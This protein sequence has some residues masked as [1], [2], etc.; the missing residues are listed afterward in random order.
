M[1][2]QQRTVDVTEHRRPEQGEIP[3]PKVGGQRLT[4]AETRN[5][6]EQEY[7]VGEI[8]YVRL[9]LDGV[10]PF[11]VESARLGRYPDSGELGV[12]YTLKRSGLKEPMHVWQKHLLD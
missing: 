6:P 10:K 4:E 1:K 11:V 8:A 7:R 12:R 5:L 2:V 3:A 9:E